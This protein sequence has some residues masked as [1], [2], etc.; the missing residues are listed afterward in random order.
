MLMKTK[1]ALRAAGETLGAIQPS[2][3]DAQAAAE[4]RR[5]DLVAAQSAVAMAEE[6]LQAAHDRSAPVGEIQKLEAA[7]V[8]ANRTADRANRAYAA[9]EKRLTKAQEAA[10]GKEKYLAIAK[11][12][13]AVEAFTKSAA[14]IDRLAAEMA[15]QVQTIE[16]QYPIFNEAKR[17]H[18]AGVYTR[19]SGGVLARMALDRAVAAQAGEWTGNRPTAADLAGNVTGAILSGA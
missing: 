14:E 16:E 2:V 17:D 9:A 11:R 10:A 6:N 7:L 8:D 3:A 5:Q 4:Q 13:A 1:Q 15:A 18:V 19:T 12:D